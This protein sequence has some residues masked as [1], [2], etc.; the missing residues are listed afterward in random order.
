MG[1]SRHWCN[2]R[3]ASLPW[4]CSSRAAA[5]RWSCG[6][7]TH[8]WCGRNLG[9]IVCCILCWKRYPRKEILWRVW[10]PQGRPLEILG[11]PTAHGGRCFRL[12]CAYYFPRAAIGQSVAG[13]AHEWGG[14]VNWGWQSGAWNRWTRSEFNSTQ[15]RQCNTK[16]T[17]RRIEISRDKSDRFGSLWDWRHFTEDYSPSKETSSTKVAEEG[18]I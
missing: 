7:C 6:L 15:W 1:S 18:F 12:G 8:T 13:T 16:W 3:P 9:P 2:R 4:M 14:W 11:S 10:N 17:G 5:N